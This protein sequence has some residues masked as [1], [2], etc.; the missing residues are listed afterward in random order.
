MSDS[1]GGEVTLEGDL[2]ATMDEHV[3]A[4]PIEESFVRGPNHHPPGTGEEDIIS[5]PVQGDRGSSDSSLDYPCESSVATS[6]DQIESSE[7]PSIA[8][9][10]ESSSLNAFDPVEPSEL[11]DTPPLESQDD[12]WGFSSAPA[13]PLVPEEWGFDSAPALPVVEFDPEVK[14]KETF[15]SCARKWLDISFESFE[16]RALSSTLVDEDLVAL[17]MEDATWQKDLPDVRWEDTETYRKYHSSLKNLLGG[18]KAALLAV[19]T[20]RTG[21][22]S[23]G[24]TSPQEQSPQIVRPKRRTQEVEED[25]ANPFS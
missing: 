24:G 5:Q 10:N 7:L 16:D 8:I 11:M 21:E 6:E 22:P 3:E 25:S 14:W 17:L 12:D 15:E 13:Q 23:D 9:L 19:T 18:Y 4:T 1:T 2:G 20:H